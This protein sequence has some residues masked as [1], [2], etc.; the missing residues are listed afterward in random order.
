MYS[1]MDPENLSYNIRLKRYEIGK[2]FEP[3]FNVR[4]LTERIPVYT[5]P[6][7]RNPTDNGAIKELL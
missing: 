4:T 3:I 7:L 5:V 6:K 2:S 1:Q